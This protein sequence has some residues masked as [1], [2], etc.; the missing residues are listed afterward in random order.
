MQAHGRAY[1]SAGVKPKFHWTGHHA[2]A[3]E[4]D[5]DLAD[6]LVVERLH[7]R[8]RE[9]AR[10]VDNIDIIEQAVCA[11]IVALHADA[12]WEQPQMG[13]RLQEAGAC[14]VGDWLEF[15]GQHYHSGHFVF[16]EDLVPLKVGFI[17]KRMDSGVVRVVVEKHVG[18]ERHAC[19]V[20]C[21]PTGIVVEAIPNDGLVP[22]FEHH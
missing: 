6:C 22:R 20:E 18:K 16:D 17:S 5:D 8:V 7:L 15:H 9:A 14:L 21:T 13:G 1:G 4:A 3:L 19:W 11:R 10:L 2:D 12:T